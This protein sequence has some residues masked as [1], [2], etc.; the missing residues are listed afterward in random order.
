[1]YSY[2]NS[3]LGLRIVDLLYRDRDGNRIS[4]TS[5]RSVPCI[6]DWAI[7]LRGCPEIW[8]CLR[9]QFGAGYLRPIPIRRNPERYC[10]VPRRLR[11]ST[12]SEPWDVPNRHRV[13]WICGTHLSL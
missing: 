5:C 12:Q 10:K 1:M 3:K 7:R 8:K 9:R 2:K 6:D 4:R 11:D 13:C